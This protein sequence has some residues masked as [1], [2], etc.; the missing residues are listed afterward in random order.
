MGLALCYQLYV[1]KSVVSV[2]LLYRQEKSDQN[3]MPQPH[4]FFLFSYMYI[5]LSYVF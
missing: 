3:S 2:V 4:W 5:F 1:G